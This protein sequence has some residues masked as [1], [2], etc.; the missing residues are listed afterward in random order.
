VQAV[1]DGLNRLGVVDCDELCQKGLRVAL[2][3]AMASMG[4]PPSLPNFEQLQQQGLDYLAAEA[5]EATGVPGPIAQIIVNKAKEF[6]EE[7]A[8]SM[9]RNYSVSGLPEWL[10]PDILLEPA[11]LTM[12]LWG[13]GEPLATK[14]LVIRKGDPI[15]GSANML[16][17]RRLP[18]PAEPSLAIPMVLQPNLEGLE[19][20]P[21]GHSEYGK[22]VWF[23][24]RWY[25]DRFVNGCYQLVLTAVAPGDFINLFQATFRVDVLPIQGC[26]K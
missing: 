10:A 15:F 4:V 17:P 13:T 5:A 6:V 7:E 8:S 24:D 20:V 25:H 19:D 16:L 23:K 18:S 21:S 3:L 11:V 2:E 12:K 9:R 26:V 1:A 14:P 22:A